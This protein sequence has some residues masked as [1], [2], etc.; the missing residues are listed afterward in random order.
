MGL[1]L[2]SGLEPLAEPGSPGGVAVGNRAPFKPG[3]KGKR[4]ALPIGSWGN[5]PPRPEHLHSQVRGT[6]SAGC[7]SPSPWSGSLFPTFL[8][9]SLHFTFLLT[10]S[11]IVSPCTCR[12][13]RERGELPSYKYHWDELLGPRPGLSSLVLCGGGG[14]GA[15]MGRWNLYSTSLLT[16]W[17]VPTFPQ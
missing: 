16:G 3:E 2:L 10:A 17:P 4:A 8:W 9:Q 6:P 15:V 7:C 13:A 14:G 12:G 5:L 1:S 11:L